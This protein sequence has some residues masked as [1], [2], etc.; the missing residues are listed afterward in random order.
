M[1]LTLSRPPP[2]PLFTVTLSMPSS[3][4]GPPPHIPDTPV[5]SRLLPPPPL[6]ILILLRAGWGRFSGQKIPTCVCFFLFQNYPQTLSAHFIEL[7]IKSAMSV[8]CV[9][10]C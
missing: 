1:L 2:P 8:T 7:L 3:D 9:V 4:R 6:Q 5:P 10:G